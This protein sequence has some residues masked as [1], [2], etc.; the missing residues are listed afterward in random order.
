M[1]EPRGWAG[2]NKSYT[3]SHTEKRY[4]DRLPVTKFATSL[5]SLHNHEHHQ[6]NNRH[7]ALIIGGAAIL[8][9]FNRH[10]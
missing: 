9:T 7:Y 10:F 4:S 8:L 3:G 6:R 5:Q 2:A 1:N